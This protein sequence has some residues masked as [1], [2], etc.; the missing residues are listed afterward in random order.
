LKGIRIT[1]QA[2]E[3]AVVHFYNWNEIVITT[4][5]VE[6][7]RWYTDIV[8]VWQ[9]GKK[10]TNRPCT[11]RRMFNT[12]SQAENYSLTLVKKWINDGKPV[13]IAKRSRETA[14]TVN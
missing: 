6:Q 10:F 3:V 9:D 11:I 13:V 14:G 5:D 1:E 2:K 8:I 7:G 12:R 4:I